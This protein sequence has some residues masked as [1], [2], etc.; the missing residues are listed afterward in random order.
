MGQI[1][2]LPQAAALRAELRAAGKKFVLTNGVFDLLHVGYLDYREQARALG[3]YLLVGV[4]GDASAHAL[5]GGGRPWVPAPER[6]RRDGDCRRGRR[7]SRRSRP[8][9]PHRSRPRGASR[10]DRILKQSASTTEG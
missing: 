2:T 9:R 1:L 3:N 6:A 10:I 4:N 7:K 8:P 5:K